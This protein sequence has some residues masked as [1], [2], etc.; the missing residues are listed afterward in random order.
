MGLKACFYFAPRPDCPY[1]MGK[2]RTAEDEE[3]EKKK[4]RK[5]TKTDGTAGP[6]SSRV[7]VAP[8][9]NIATS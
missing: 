1:N 6:S 4:R 8:K 2:K 3:R 5:M 9:A 7:A